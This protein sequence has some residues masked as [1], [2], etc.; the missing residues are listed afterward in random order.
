MTKHNLEASEAA[1]L[2]VKHL[3]TLAAG[4]LALSGTFLGRLM[5]PNPLASGFL[6]TA[7]VALVTSIFFGLKTVSTIISSRLRDNNRWC[8]GRGKTFATLSKWSFFAGITAFIIFALVIVSG[9]DMNQR[10][11]ETESEKYS[12]A[13][14]KFLAETDILLGRLERMRLDIESLKT[15]DSILKDNF[16]EL[17][18]RL[19]EIYIS[20]DNSSPR[21]ALSGEN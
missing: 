20:E 14:D 6:I 2:F 21:P 12:E 5:P 10:S 3:L 18:D 11:H 7:W 16:L 17:K 4:V 19:T 15:S 1:L 9:F 8:D 13:A